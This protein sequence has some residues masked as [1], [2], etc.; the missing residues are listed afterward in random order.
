MQITSA[1]VT[2][3]RQIQLKPYH[4]VHLEVT[5]VA[6]LIEGD[7]VDEATKA[8]WEKAVKDVQTQAQPLITYYKEQAEAEAQKVYNGLP[9]QVR[10]QMKG[11]Q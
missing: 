2:Y 8:L 11:N 1:T 7:N 10:N 5:L 4:G 9:E 3:G 6:N